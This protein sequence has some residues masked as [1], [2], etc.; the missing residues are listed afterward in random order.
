MTVAA[1][2][3]QSIRFHSRSFH[4]MTLAPETPLSDWLAELD[5]WLER[6]PDFF[7][8]RPIALD[9]SA[10]EATM[11]ETIQLTKDLRE[12]K[13]EVLGLEGADRAWRDAELPPLLNSGGRNDNAQDSVMAALDVDQP[14]PQAP[15]P[16]PHSLLVD[17]P[18]RSGQYIE[19]L[20]GDVI[21]VGSVASGAEIVAG[22]SIH[23]YGALRGRAIAGAD[24]PRARIFCRK[25]EAELLAIDGLYMTA[26]DMEPHLRGRSVQVWLD[27]ETV[28]VTAQD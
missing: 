8:G 5:G 23:I 16:R 6:S 17:S 15:P 27:G 10:C 14:A 2:P 20:A 22:G 18:V 11:A 19:H 25:L 26:D 28:M 9:I 3:R 7:I 13:I 1:R 4:A 24:D 12:R 21:V